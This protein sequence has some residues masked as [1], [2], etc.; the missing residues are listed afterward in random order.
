M[1]MLFSF[2]FFIFMRLP[3]SAIYFRSFLSL[4]EYLFRPFLVTYKFPYCY[5]M[6]HM[7]ETVECWCNKPID[8]DLSANDRARRGQT[9]GL[10]VW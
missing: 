4:D 2:F 5:N 1:V 6:F 8:R 10:P 3:R 7:K 9:S